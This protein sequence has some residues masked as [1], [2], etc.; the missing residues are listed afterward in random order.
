MSSPLVVASGGGSSRRHVRI[1]AAI[2]P[3]VRAFL[4]KTDLPSRTGE[5]SRTSRCE[6][7]DE[8]DE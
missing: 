1:T 2:A 3:N 5:C 8:I 4:D 6:T 7:R